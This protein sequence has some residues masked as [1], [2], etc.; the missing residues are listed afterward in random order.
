[1]DKA[2]FEAQLKKEAR[3]N[4]LIDENLGMVKVNG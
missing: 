3:L 4:V 2:E 1:M